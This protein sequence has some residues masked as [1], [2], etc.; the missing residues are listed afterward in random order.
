MFVVMYLSSRATMV[1]P[2]ISNQSQ[3]G[4][5]PTGV[6]AM[7]T[8][9]RPPQKPAQHIEYAAIVRADGLEIPITEEM[10]RRACETLEHHWRYPQNKAPQS[11]RPTV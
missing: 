7:Q 2:S 11:A 5:I 1:S 4:A 9:H 8:T 3:I 6:R 10:I